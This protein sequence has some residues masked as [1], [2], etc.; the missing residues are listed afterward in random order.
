MVHAQAALDVGCQFFVE[1]PHG[2]GHDIPYQGAPTRV[3]VQ[4]NFSPAVRG[5]AGCAHRERHAVPLQRATAA[6]L[7]RDCIWHQ[8]LRAQGDARLSECPCVCGAWVG[9]WGGW[10]LWSSR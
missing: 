1:P 7:H 4:P 9:G 3:Y 6:I 2:A 8:R 10:G 5:N